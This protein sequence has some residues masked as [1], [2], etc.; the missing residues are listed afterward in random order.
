MMGGFAMPYNSMTQNPM[1]LTFTGTGLGVLVMASNPILDAGPPGELV[2]ATWNGMWEG[3]FG[4]PMQPVQNGPTPL[5]IQ[6]GPSL[7]GGATK[8]L[9]AY[10]GLDSNFYY[11]QFFNGS[12]AP[13]NEP[14][15]NGSAQSTGPVPPAIAALGD[16]PTIA[17]VGTDGDLYDQTR[18][19]GTWGAP[20]KHGVAGHTASITPTIIALTMG[21]ELLLVYADASNA[22]QLMYTTRTSG[23]WSA[24]AAL[25]TAQS[26]AQVSL[27]PLV[28]GGAVLAYMDPTGSLYTSILS[29][30]PGPTWSLPVAG[31]NGSIPTLLG[32]PAVASGP[33]GSQATLL[34]TNLSAIAFEAQLN[35]GAWGAPVSAGSSDAWL[36]IATGH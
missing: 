15:P 31:V 2:F 24:P 11:A 26:P 28:A 27:A 3:S 14:I 23:T 18:S 13:T 4:Q 35:G 30:G 7:A 17:F 12:W 21:P 20:H 34:Y 36:A 32:P 6:G 10:Q 33:S 29:A 19:C 16:D 5:Q 9:C 22:N 8:G 1:G 25:S